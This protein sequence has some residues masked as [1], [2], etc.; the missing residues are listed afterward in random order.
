MKRVT[1]QVL[2]ALLA[3]IIIATSVPFTA[4]AAEENTQ[5]NQN[6]TSDTSFSGSAGL[7]LI[8]EN[9]VEGEENED[10]VIS[11]IEMDG[12]KAYVDVSNAD[13]CKLIVAIYD[14]MTMQMLASGMAEVPTEHGEIEVDIDIESMPEHFIVKA[15]LLDEQLAPLCKSYE[16]LEYTSEFE[17]YL[18][19]TPE[20]FNN[21]NIIVFDDTKEIIDFAVLGDETVVAGNNAEMTFSYDEANGT[22]T[23]FN[24]T[25]EVKNLSDG[26]IYYYEYGTKSNEFLLIKVKSIDVSGADVEILEDKDISLEEAFSFVRIDAEGD[27]DDVEID[28]SQLGSAL[29]VVETFD[30]MGSDPEFD[31]DTGEKSWSTT[32]GVNWKLWNNDSNPDDDPD[33]S[34]LEAS[35]SGTLGYEL[36]TSVKLIYDVKLFGKDYY[37]FKSEIKHKITPLRDWK[38]L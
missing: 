6:V 29:T 11:Y 3:I 30:T 19:K 34:T 21:E 16:S 33:D 38:N 7:N 25:D 9:L 35:I 8:A 17:I 31:V 10:Y 28:E 22:Y 4:F 36:S 18:E 15:Y 1:K 32:L 14:E 37:E 2:S 13:V 5:G 26:D 23:F 20:D 12:N 27:Y 24:A